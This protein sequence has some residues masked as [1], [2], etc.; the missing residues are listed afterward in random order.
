VI[1]ALADCVIAIQGMTGKARTSQATQG[2]QRIIDATQAHLEAHPQK[3]EETTTPDDTHN[4][5]QV[6][7]VQTPLSAPKSHINDDRQITCSMQPQSPVLR[8]PTNNPTGKPISA[9]FLETTN[10]PTGNPGCVPGIKPT[11][12]PANSSKRERIQK[13]QAA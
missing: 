11:A 6:H 8:V 13:W 5:Q 12:L 9:T 10:N 2:R 4:T 7:R 1:H 3:F